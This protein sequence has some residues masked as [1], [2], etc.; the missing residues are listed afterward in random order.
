MSKVTNVFFLFSFGFIFVV[1]VELL[2]RNT[3]DR[4]DVDDDDDFFC[5][6]NNLIRFHSLNSFIFFLSSGFPII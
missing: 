1:V 2:N 5:S 3:I 4:V 6:D